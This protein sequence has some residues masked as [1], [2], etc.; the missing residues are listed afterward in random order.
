MR[1]PA[2]RRNRTTAGI[3]PQVASAAGVA[4]VVVCGFWCGS[5]R[6][7]GEDR[8][9]G[10]GPCAEGGV[11]ASLVL[12]AAHPGVVA[13]PGEEDGEPGG[14]RD[15]EQGLAGPG[16]ERRGGEEEEEEGGGGGCDGRVERA[17]HAEH[18]GEGA[19]AAAAVLLELVE[20][21]ER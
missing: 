11:H 3:G 10:H 20:L 17:A 15:Q 13:Q 6:E 19:V 5:E 9:V 14:A 16:G 1:G 21:R 7:D 2:G 12:V 18:E 4:G 8:E